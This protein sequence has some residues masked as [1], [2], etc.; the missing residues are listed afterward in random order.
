MSSRFVIGAAPGS[1]AA[2]AA[3]DATAAPLRLHMERGTKLI[4]APRGKAS[5]DVR[6]QASI[7]TCL[8]PSS[9]VHA[10]EVAQEDDA[11]QVIVDEGTHLTK[12]VEA[13]YEENVASLSLNKGDLLL[14]IFVHVSI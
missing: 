7:S 5:V 14:F 4:D 2:D 12:V 1:S 10:T 3:T 8:P 6:S 11:K 9:N 13:S